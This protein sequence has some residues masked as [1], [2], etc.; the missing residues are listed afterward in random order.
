MSR[1][2]NIKKRA[3]QKARHLKKLEDAKK[4]PKLS[5]GLISDNPTGLITALADLANQ[6]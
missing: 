2:G 6:T 5:R 1:R 4:A 3:K